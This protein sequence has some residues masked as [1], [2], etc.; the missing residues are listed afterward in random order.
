[1]IVQTARAN[2]VRV[3]T[4]NVAYR[5][6]TF[7]FSHGDSYHHTMIDEPVSEWKEMT[8]DKNKEEN[9]ILNR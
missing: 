7:V 5:A 8:W 6:N 3:V 2:G 4:W 9:K 1:M